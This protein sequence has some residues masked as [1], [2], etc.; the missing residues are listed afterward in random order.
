MTKTTPVYAR[1][2]SSL[3]ERAEEILAKLGI[4]PS[5]LIQMLYSQVILREGV[6]FELNLGIQAPK[7][8][9]SMTRAEIDAELE[10]GL[11]SL[12]EGKF[13]TAKEVAEKFGLEE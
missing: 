7:A 11:K 8:L 10:K 13:Y 1:I 2:D 9:G 6:P 3:K 12:E 4:T 5:S